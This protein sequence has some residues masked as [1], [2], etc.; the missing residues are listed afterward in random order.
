MHIESTSQESPYRTGTLTG[1]TLA[2]IQRMLS[3]IEPDSRPT[4]DRKV[5]ITWRF[6]A[7][8]KPCGIWNYR[9]SHEMRGELSTFGPDEILR[10]LFGKAYSPI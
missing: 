8:G 1:L 3:D 2:D 9:R 5:S 10:A 4:A 7:N 6:L